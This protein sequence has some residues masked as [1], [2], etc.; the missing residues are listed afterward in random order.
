MWGLG[1]LA[2]VV[3]VFDRASLG[4]AGL[5]AQQRFGTTAAVLSLFGVVQL[6]VYAALQVPVG[7]L[8][9]RI[10]SRRMIAAGALL[11]AGG[12]LLLANADGVPTGLLARVLVGAGDAMTFI[13]VL[14]LVP[15]WFPA[16]RVPVVSQLTGLL[17]QAGQVVAAYP[18]VAGLHGPGWTPTFST[19]A[20]VGVV[21][22]VLVLLGL[23]NA[24]A[25]V[26]PLAA[27][28]GRRAALR[29]SWREAGTRLGLWT[30]F[31][32]Q[33]S[34][35]TFALFWGYPYLVEAQ[36]LSPAAASGLLTLLVVTGMGLGPLLGALAGRWPARRSTMVLGIVLGSAATWT[37]VLA[38][39]GRAPLP[40]LVLLA[41][42]L[43]SNGPGSMVGFDFARTE[44]PPARLGSASGIV[45]VGGFLATLLTILAVGLLL[46]ASGSYRVALCVQYLFWA[47]GLL[48]VLRHRRTVRRR[49]GYVV[50]ALPKAVARKLAATR[51]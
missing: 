17:G 39:P 43:A 44:N 7:V 23:R 16:R 36:G 38:W 3:A 18:L 15:A 14:R 50:D 30:H 21:V 11:M 5:D 40:V 12:Q 4:V 19:A 8:L 29:A 13:S 48:G 1:V 33:F 46:D 10:G 47:V 45:N 28:D 31:V 51:S 27:P 37:L 2:Y 26:A 41:L 32:T 42:A 25:G 9:D 49:R 22:S 24:P 34:G 35:N 20:A 6:G